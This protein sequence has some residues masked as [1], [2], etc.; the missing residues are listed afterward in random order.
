MN[1]VLKVQKWFKALL[2]LEVFLEITQNIW[3][4]V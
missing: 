2:H 3:K 1:A 4:I